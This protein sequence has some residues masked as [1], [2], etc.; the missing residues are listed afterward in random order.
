MREID[1][2]K[3]ADILASFER[4]YF[5]MALS[6]CLA[7]LP[8]LKS[9]ANEDGTINYG[10]ARTLFRRLAVERRIKKAVRTDRLTKWGSNR[11]TTVNV[12]SPS[13]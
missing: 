6:S 7:A 8:S 12:K 3:P 11:S 10:N 4:F 5:D 13:V 9:F 2:P 1:G